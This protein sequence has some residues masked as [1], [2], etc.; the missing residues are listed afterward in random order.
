MHV[1][2]LWR[3]PVKSM[4]GEPRAIRVA[5]LVEL[6]GAITPQ[7]DESGRVR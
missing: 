7:L 2:E 5:E 1:A 6:V 3:F 4:A